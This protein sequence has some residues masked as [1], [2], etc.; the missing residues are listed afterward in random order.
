MARK[1]NSDRIGNSFSEKTKEEVWGKGQIINGF[2]SSQTRKDRCGAWIRW[3]KY[4]DTEEN[5]YGWEIDHIKPVSIGGG[6]ELTNLQPL[7]WENNRKKG[8]KYPELDYCTVSA[9]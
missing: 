6:D 5:G 7:Q 1:F 2:D 8:D 9:K 3:D 4:G